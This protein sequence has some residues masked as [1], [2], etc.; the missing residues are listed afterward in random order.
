MELVGAAGKDWRNM[1]DLKL[2]FTPTNAPVGV[3]VLALA[4]ISLKDLCPQSRSESLWN[5]DHRHGVALC[6]RC[7]W[8]FA[9]RIS[10]IEYVFAHELKYL[11]PVARGFQMRVDFLNSFKVSDAL[12]WDVEREL[13]GSIAFVLHA[14]GLGKGGFPK[15]LVQDPFSLGPGAI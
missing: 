5:F 9:Q 6:K 1:V 15:M 10:L 2:K 11:K 3:F 7:L 4:M 8:L 14:K 12:L 13:N